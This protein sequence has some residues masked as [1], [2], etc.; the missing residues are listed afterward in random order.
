MEFYPIL[1][2]LSRKILTLTMIIRDD[3]IL[4]GMKKR[5]LGMGKWNGFGGKVELNES[6]EEGAIREV[7]EECG[8][9]VIFMEK[10]GILEFDYID[11][12]ELLEGHVYICSQFSGNIV[13]TEDTPFDTMWIDHKYWYPLLLK[14]I[15]FKAYFKYKGHDKILDY[16]ITLLNSQSKF[17]TKCISIILKRNS[18]IFYCKKNQKWTCFSWVHEKMTENQSFEK[19]IE[20]YFSNSYEKV[21]NKIHKIAV[22]NIELIDENFISETTV[23]IV[24]MSDLSDVVQ[25]NGYEWLDINDISRG[26][27]WPD[28]QFLQT[29]FQSKSF[30]AYFLINTENVLFSKYYDL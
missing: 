11:S 16:N 27:Q 24:D 7:K 3:E 25:V 15:P 30:G 23:Y 28:I 6:I 19:I 10:I 5:G 9:D 12:K 17:K 21:L 1:E 26:S 2:G 4:L 20:R 22:V 18:K 14:K 29:I 8:L 13:E